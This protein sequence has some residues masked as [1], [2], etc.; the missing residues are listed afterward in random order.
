MRS[1]SHY[2]QLMQSVFP[3][4]ALLSEPAAVILFFMDTAQTVA[5]ALGLL[6]LLGKNRL[7]A[8]Q[9]IE[10]TDIHRST[11]YRLLGTLSQLGYIRKNEDSGLYS[12]SP[13]ILTL[14]SSVSETKDIKEIALPYIDELHSKIQETIHLAVL[15]ND[16]LVYLDKRES[17]RNLRVAMS[18]KPGSHAPLYCT[19][20]G[21]VLLSGMPDSQLRDYLKTVRFVKYT[22]N[23]LPGIQELFSEIDEIKQQGYAEDREEHEEGVYCVAAPV[24][25]AEGDTIA[26]FS[27][28][29]PSVRRTDKLR[30]EVID[31]VKNASQKISEAVG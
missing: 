22:G 7:T 2:M 28:S 29:M 3:T 10:Q 6:E 23:T 16:E 27:I 4:K 24:F 31:A 15:D 30:L 21:K 1:Y 18:S 14:A 5:R 9:I 20:I 12:L 26:A 25:N 13:K 17:S 19:G 11:I 8:T